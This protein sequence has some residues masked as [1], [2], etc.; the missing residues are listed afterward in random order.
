VDWDGNGAPGGGNGAYD[1]ATRTGWLLMQG[2]NG[3]HVELYQDSALAAGKCYIAKL[4]PAVSQSGAGDG[5]VQVGISLSDSASGH[6][7]TNYI[8]LLLEEDATAF[9]I[10]VEGGGTYSGMSASLSETQSP[11]REV[12]LRLDRTT[13]GEYRASIS[14]NG[15]SWI[16]L[17]DIAV[18]TVLTKAWIFNHPIAASSQNTPIQAIDWVRLGDA[19]SLDP[20]PLID[21]SSVQP[22]ITGEWRGGLARRT[23]T[24]SFN[25]ATAT[26][27]VW[28][29]IIED[30]DGFF[31]IGGANAERITI[32]TGVTRVRIKAQA[33]IDSG[34]SDAMLYLHKNG[35]AVEGLGYSDNKTDS[36]DYCSATSHP[37]EVVAGDYIDAKV[38]SASSGTI[39]DGNITWISVE[40]VEPIVAITDKGSVDISNSDSPYTVATSKK[41]IYIDATSVVEIDLPTVIGN[42]NLEYDI[43]I[44]T[45][46]ANVTLDPNSTENIEGGSS[47]YVFSGANQSRTIKAKGLGSNAGW[48][49]I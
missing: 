7:V 4:S 34:S 46:S 29:Q 25:A 1:L 5:S 44:V 16:F 38:Y 26:V 35:A 2:G 10:K 19:D 37:I 24:Q 28:Q 13:A 31:N 33:R 22:V 48:W 43:K 9:S 47:S 27:I 30:T 15:T 42:H 21:G 41:T 32:P 17:D 11:G 23:A 18:G 49:I 12:F 20:W 8:R 39:T 6:D 40:V 36:H 45:G 14:F 3:E